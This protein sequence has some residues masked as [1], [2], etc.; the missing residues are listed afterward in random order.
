MEEADRLCNRIA[1]IDHG[2]I[3][4]LDTPENLKNGIGGDV[5]T[6]RSSDP[7]AI[8][9]ALVEPWITRVEHHND[10]VIV[11][12][13]NAEQ[14]IS[15]IVTLLNE[16]QVPIDSLAIHKP[17]LE[18]VFLSFTGKTIREEEADHKANMR[19]YQKM[20]RH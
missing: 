5:V 18:D 7:A 6:I 16:K 15:T 13:K 10:E 20:A 19:M 14:H 11:S 12:L 2:K 8:V 3:I 4:A 9:A 17:T 1:I